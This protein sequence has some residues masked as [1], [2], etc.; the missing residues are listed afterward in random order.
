MFPMPSFFLRCV[1]LLQSPHR[2]VLAVGGA[3]ILGVLAGTAVLMWRGLDDME[4]HDQ[5]RLELMAS[6]LDAHV[7]QVF[8]VGGQ[9]LDNLANSLQQAPDALDRLEAQQQYYLQ[10]LPFLRSL[11]LVSEEGRVLVSTQQ[12][13]RAGQVD[14]QRLVTQ[15]VRGERMAIGPWT[16]GRTLTEKAS[17]GTSSRLGFIPLLRRVQLPN[18]RHVLL[19]AQF[20]PDALAQYQQQLLDLNSPDT[21]VYLALDDGRLLSHVGHDALV[22]GA[23]LDGHV[24]FRMKAARKGI[25]GPVQTL[26]ERSLG[27]W[28]RAASQPL[29]SLVEQP[30]ASTLRRWLLSLRGPLAFMALAL[31]LI[32]LMTFSAW[33]NARARAVA[34]RE[35]DEAL[36]EIARREQE[37]SVLFKSVQELIF[38]TDPQGTLRFVNARWQAMTQ[39]TPESARGRHLRDMV[40]PECRERIDALF[41]PGRPPGVR[42]AQAQLMG[43]NGEVRVLDVSV[44]PLLARDGRLRGFAGSAAD[45]TTL[46][47]AQM[48]LQEQL[49]FSRQ[50][51]ESNP[52]PVCLTDLEGHF[53]MVNQ[54]WE[55][56]MG[57][58][59]DKVLGRH[60]RDFLPPQEAQAYDAHSDELLRVGGQ[61]RY[62]ERLHR[63]DGSVRDVQVTKVRLLS[64]QGEPMGLLIVKMDITDYLAAR[65]L[66]EQASRTQ[67]EFVANISHELRTPLQSILGF[68]ELGMLRGRQHEKLAAMFGDIHA[69]GQRMLELVNDLLDMSKIDSTVGAFHFEPHDVRDIIEA[70]AAELASQLQGKQLT[71]NLQLGRLPLEAKVDPVR[72]AQVIRNVLANA[73]KFSPEGRA[74]QISAG[75]SDDVTIHIAVRDQGPGIPP[76]ELEAVFQ[77][78]VQ[79]SKTRD[80]S[81]GTGLGLAICQK[82][83]TAHGGHIHAANVPGGGAIFHITLPTAGYTDT[84]PAALQ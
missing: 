49:A 53:L 36:Q 55:H 51:L 37:L 73:V 43:A 62:E 63:P 76:T 19:V 24:Y 40:L 4:Q 61:I 39:Q 6:V 12:A 32:G 34:R 17:P 69:A 13:D 30:Y 1:R 78:F 21:R 66:A 77:A 81:G 18:G 74:I 2:R 25:Y 45:V 7:G 48:H 5:Q 10:S 26:G 3:L 67:S 38:R 57:L 44:V 84:M 70:V 56:F 28:Q 11:A 72:F 29:V 58:S 31:M 52:L 46:L 23:S 59:R 9:A 71:L 82:I 22:Q 35:R 64:H 8:E 54:A 79:S 15:P 83:V 33:R 60:N 41:A 14:L 20:S 75:L 50:L 47:A 68:S 27:A 65:D 80:G 42:T 16:P